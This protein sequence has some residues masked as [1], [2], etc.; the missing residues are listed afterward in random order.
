[1]RLAVLSLSSA[2]QS[3]MNDFGMST[4]LLGRAAQVGRCTLERLA[5]FA[6]GLGLDLTLT[7]WQEVPKK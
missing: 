2:V 6:G 4:R 5:Q 1:M 3:L 7:G